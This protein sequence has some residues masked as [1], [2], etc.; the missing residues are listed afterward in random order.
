[1]G[2]PIPDFL[3]EAAALGIFNRAQLDALV[4]PARRLYNASIAEAI[5]HIKRHVDVELEGRPDPLLK[6]LSDVAAATVVEGDFD[7]SGI[8][9]AVRDAPP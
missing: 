1:M 7:V 3:A 6:K 4:L 8:V 9:R 2:E 5:L